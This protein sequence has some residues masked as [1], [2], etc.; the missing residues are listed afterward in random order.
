[1]L[2]EIYIEALLLDEDVANEVLE[3]LESGQIDLDTAILNGR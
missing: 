2:T 1:M 3:M